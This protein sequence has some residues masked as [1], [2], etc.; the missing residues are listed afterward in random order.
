MQV[1]THYDNLQVAQNASLRVIRAAWKSL[2]QEWHPDKQPQDLQVA[3]RVL[4]IINRAYEVLSNPETKRQH[5]DWIQS[6]KKNQKHQD[7]AQEEDCESNNTKYHDGKKNQSSSYVANEQNDRVFMKDY[8]YFQD[9]AR[10]SA[11]SHFQDNWSDESAIV[12]IGLIFIFF[13]FRKFISFQG[14]STSCPDAF[15]FWHSRHWSCISQSVGR[16]HDKKSSG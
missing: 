1:R 11:K 10:R 3:E 2:A 15:Y 7:A 16:D 12:P 4:K 13:S 5:D 8:R 14:L 6:Q 9:Y